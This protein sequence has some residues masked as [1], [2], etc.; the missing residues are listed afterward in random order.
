MHF[1]R[2]KSCSLVL[3]AA[4]LLSAGAA[5]AQTRLLKDNDK[6]L[7]LPA[8]STPKVPIR[9][10]CSAYG[11]GFMRVEG[12]DSCVKVGGSVGVETGRRTRGR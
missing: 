10:P 3:T 2:A 5:F 9:N 8:A 12:S 11:P 4:A 6:Q 1:F 7:D